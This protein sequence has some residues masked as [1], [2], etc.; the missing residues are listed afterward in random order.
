MFLKTVWTLVF[1]MMLVACGYR[2]VLP[3]DGCSQANTIAIPFVEGD[4]KG[5]L[6]Q[7]LIYTLGL[8]TPLVY[9]DGNAAYLLQVKLLKIDEENIGFRYDRNR[10]GKLRHTV[11]PT[12]MRLTAI[13]E[14]T[15]SST[16]TGELVIPL[17]IVKASLDFDHDY[18]FDRDAVNVF[19]LGQLADVDA[20]REA[21]LPPLYRNLARKI[22]DTVMVKGSRCG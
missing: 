20:A 6:T 13:A 8:R 5:I 16:E 9:K 10:K 12:E 4:R 21:A 3:L 22:V 1:G 15:L 11:I 7:T 14:I 19:S 17:T 18:Y 2:T